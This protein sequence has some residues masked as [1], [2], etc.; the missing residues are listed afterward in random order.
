MNLLAAVGFASS[1]LQFIDFGTE[2]C[3]RIREYSSAVNGN[4]KKL[5]ELG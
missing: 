5:L 3:A 2:L 1:L 4:P